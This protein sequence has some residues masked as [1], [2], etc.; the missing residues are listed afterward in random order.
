M[1]Q[2]T[3]KWTLVVKLTSKAGL[4][5]PCLHSIISAYVCSLSKVGGKTIYEFI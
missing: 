3:E 2:K 5:I 4:K 1:L